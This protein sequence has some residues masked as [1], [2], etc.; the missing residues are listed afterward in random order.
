MPLQF[1]EVVT[2]LI[3]TVG[4]GRELER[5]EDGFVDLFGRPAADG[6]AAMEEN[7]QQSDNPGVVDFDSGIAY[8]ADG[9]GQGEPL[10]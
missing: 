3:Q 9:D 5:G 4:F 7:L 10:Q 6:V 8:G 1:A 2:E